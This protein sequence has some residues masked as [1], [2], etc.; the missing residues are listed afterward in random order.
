MSKFV[1]TVWND[2][3]KILNIQIEVTYYS[4]VTTSLIWLTHFLLH[5]NFFRYFNLSFKSIF[6]ILYMLILVFKILVSQVKFTYT[7]VTKFK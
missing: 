4:F 7:E 2:F 1:E 3:I 5:L 6:F